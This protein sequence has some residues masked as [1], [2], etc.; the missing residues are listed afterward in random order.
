MKMRKICMA[1]L[2]AG[3]VLLASG[4]LQYAQAADITFPATTESTFNTVGLDYVLDIRPNLTDQLSGSITPQGGV[5]EITQT[6]GTN[7]DGSEFLLTTP[8][9]TTIELDALSNTITVPYDG[10]YNVEN[11]Q[12]VPGY[13]LDLG[14][15]AD[16]GLTFGPYRYVF[17]VMS[18]SVP[19]SH[20]DN[21][22]VHVEP[23]LTEVRGDIVFTKTDATGDIPLEGAEFRLIQQTDERTGTAG[24]SIPNR[25]QRTISSDSYGLVEFNDLPEGTYT[26]QELEAPWGYMIDEREMNYEVTVAADQLTVEVNEITAEAL[27]EAGNRINYS[28]PS[29]DKTVAT[30]GTLD[31]DMY[32]NIADLEAPSVGYLEASNIDRGIRYEFDTVLPENIEDYVQYQITDTFHPVFDMDSLATGDVAVT[33][34]GNTVDANI[35]IEGR[36]LTIS[37]TE[38]QLDALGAIVADRVTPLDLSVVFEIEVDASHAEAETGTIVSN[39]VELAWDN[40]MGAVG[41]QT[42]DVSVEL[43]EGIVEVL[44]HDANLDSSDPNY[45]LSDTVFVLYRQLDD[46]QVAQGM[47]GETVRGVDNL[48][49]ATDS[50]GNDVSVVETDSNGKAV[51][52]RVPFGRYYLQEVSAPAGYR[53]NQELTEFMV[54]DT[55]DTVLHQGVHVGDGVKIEVA[56]HKASDWFP[57]TGTFGVL[58]FGAAAVTLVIGSIALGRQK[59]DEEE[60]E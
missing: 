23:K 11:T 30:H 22:S 32:D 18:D 12:R 48:V 47:T 16:G 21:Q 53:L 31:G 44:K 59:E 15:T 55:E 39:V 4:G 49:P 42:S 10:V 5:Y 52:P 8:I 29:V 35:N 58:G 20:Y 51:V 57:A 38:A 50:N 9:V 1:S 14:Y 26:V 34:N 24:D 6:H 45:Y 46:V 13:L 17:P 54:S 36:T 37:F 7:A 56:N 43:K 3:Q 19:P 28:E 40:G 2:I 25:I 27:L 41:S 33:V 60:V